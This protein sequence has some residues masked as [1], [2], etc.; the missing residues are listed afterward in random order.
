MKKIDSGHPSSLR[1]EAEATPMFDMRPSSPTG[2]QPI[3]PSFPAI[4]PGEGVNNLATKPTRFKQ[5]IVV[6]SEGRT[7]KRGAAFWELRYTDPDT[8]KDVKR[9]VT[10]VDREEITAMAD[11]LTRRAYQGKGYLAGQQKAPS[12]EEGIVQAVRLSAARAEC[13]TDYLRRARFF[14]VYMAEHYPA[15]HTWGDVR[16][17][18]VESYLRTCEET[19]LAYDSIRLRLVPVK[20]T[21][22]RM[23]QDWPELVRPVPRLRLAAPPRREV[24][25]LDAIEL[26]TLLEWLKGHIPAL[27]PMAC[28]QGLAGLRMQEASSLRV[29]DVDFEAKTVKVCD[30]GRHRPKTR[31]SYRTI[32]VCHDVVEALRWA[33]AHQ[34][35]RPATGELFTNRSGNTWE[36]GQLSHRWSK[37]IRQA[38]RELRDADCGSEQYAERNRRAERLASIPA[39]KLRAAFAT[40]ASRLGA[41]DRIL[42]AYL[43]HSAGDMLGGHYRQIGMD[44]LRV[45]SDLMNGWQRQA[46]VGG[47]RKDSG[48]N[49]PTS[50]VEA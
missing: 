43:G 4:R 17:G 40:L 1:V 3:R 10:G 45:V 37:A 19:G 11:H 15:V 34:K 20:L 23:Y 2:L 30:T 36:R 29:Q 24:T 33:L 25:C 13:K 28:L 27:W 46:A 38:A 14:L 31:D 50:V 6:V 26:A 21:W 44:E 32:P 35:V 39:R 9:R 12:L 42:K 41:Q 49:A 22:R 18:M 7:P 8:G 5:G 47:F 48:N 16:S